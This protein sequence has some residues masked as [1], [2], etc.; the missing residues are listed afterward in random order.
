MEQATHKE[1]VVLPTT[2][3]PS[4]YNITLQPDLKNFTFRYDPRPVCNSIS[5]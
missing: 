2:V 4:K 3:K 5:L 1:R